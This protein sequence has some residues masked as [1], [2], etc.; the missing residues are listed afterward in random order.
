MDK[1]ESRSIEDRI[2]LLEQRNRRMQTGLLGVVLFALIPWTFAA[3]Q[4]QDAGIVKAT[5]LHLMG[6]GNVS[7]VLKPA[8]GGF[9]I[10]NSSGVQLFYLYGTRNG[11]MLR[12]FGANGKEVVEMGGATGR[13]GTPAESIV[14]GFVS[15]RSSSGAAA[16]LYA[17][18]DAGGSISVASGP[19][20]IAASM[21]APS[22]NGRFLVGNGTKNVASLSV[23]DQSNGL[24]EI[25]N[26]SGIRVALLGVASRE[27]GWL[28]LRSGSGKPRIDLSGSDSKNEPLGMFTGSSGK[29]SLILGSTVLGGRIGVLNGYEQ[30]VARV[31][32]GYEPGFTVIDAI[33]GKPVAFLVNDEEGGV[34]LI[35]DINGNIEAELPR[36]H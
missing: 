16:H 17:S 3:K 25:W 36:R 21:D 12:V 33:S 7:A 20:K 8:P 32:A 26:R 13:A 35:K 10:F 29:L 23:D 24:F 18:P 9:G 11:G 14:G 2:V 19:G 5:E 15:A 27:D 31:D 30:L 28:T 4:Q 6:S 1:G 34:V 22:G